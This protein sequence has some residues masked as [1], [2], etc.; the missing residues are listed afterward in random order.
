[1]RFKN[2][3]RVA[4]AVTA[5]LIVALSWYPPLQNLANEQ[6]DAGLKR[7]LISFASA[8]TL[9]AVIS[10]VQGTELS[11][12]PLGIGVTLTLGQALDPVND[13]VEQF[14]SLMLYASVAFGVQKALLAIGANWAISLAVSVVALAWAGLSVY[15]RAP[16]WL[17]RLL[18]VLLLVR[19][20]IPVVTLGSD[21][22]YRQLLEPEYLEHQQSIDAVAGDIAEVAPSMPG[23]APKTPSGTTEA[24]PPVPAP[25][26]EAPAAGADQ[27]TVWE[28]MRDAVTPG[29]PSAEQ[30]GT[31][32]PTAGSGE[33]PGWWE[34]LKDRFGPKLPNLTLDLESIKTSVEGL[35]ERIIRLTVIFLL[36]T[37][38]V[39]ILLLWLLYRV[40]VG[41]VRPEDRRP[42]N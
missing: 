11:M 3:G 39:P 31:D 2:L 33:E 26:A 6:V 14:S 17:S 16:P 5:L 34:T 36:Q 30:P 1:M 42:A 32:Q 22:L 8:R 7:A 9:N 21:F 23:V 28:K 38:I 19:F 18:L 15:R 4:L 25:S 24:L 29:A 10:V 37:M 12:Q 35:P 13:L 27:R 41:L 40:A 20:A